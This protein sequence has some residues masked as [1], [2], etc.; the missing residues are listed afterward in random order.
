MAYQNNAPANQRA[1]NALDVSKLSLS[2]PS[3]AEGKWAF[4]SF[5]LVKNNPRIEIRTNDPADKANHPTA[6]GK[7]T[8]NMDSPG[9]FGLVELIK[10]IADLPADTPVDKTR[11]AIECRGYTF[12]GGKRS[13]TPAVISTVWVGKDMEKGVWISVAVKDRPRIKFYFQFSQWFNM[14]GGDGKPFEK[15]QSSVL[16]AKGYANMLSNL[17]AVVMDTAFVEE[18]Y[19]QGA[20]GNNNNGG[21]QQQQ[22]GGQQGGNN[23]Y[24][25]NN[26][27]GGGQQSSGGNSG[28]T[29]SATGDDFTDDI[30]F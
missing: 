9:L 11:A 29:T 1:K 18:D 4:M 26:G 6:Y 23:N 19:G 3:S 10:Y 28:T 12:F 20:G 5:A 16:F 25:Q 14:V 2:A 8:A 15:V 27:G 30:P 17:Y 22:R 24:R 13:E 7:L 21:G